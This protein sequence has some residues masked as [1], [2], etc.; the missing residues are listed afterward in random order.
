ME[1]NFLEKSVDFNQLLD[2]QT[3]Y[4]EKYVLKNNKS[5]LRK[6]FNFFA[7]SKKTA[8]KFGSYYYF[9]YFS[10]KI[11]HSLTIIYHD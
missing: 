7:S 4:A 11:E 6:I 5:S 9:F 8:I 2:S 1:N 3:E 10:T